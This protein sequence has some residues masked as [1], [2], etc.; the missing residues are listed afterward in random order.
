MKD[1]GLWRSLV[2]LWFSFFGASF[3]SDAQ[4]ENQRLE[5]SPAQ[6]WN[7]LTQLGV[8]GGVDNETI[9]RRIAAMEARYVSLYAKVLTEHN[10]ERAEEA[11]GCVLSVGSAEAIGH[12][13]F[14]EVF[15]GSL[16]G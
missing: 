5:L 1:R 15:S 11:N 2:H 10:T 3:R 12:Q 16:G 14:S 8:G 4:A 6:T 13:C 9:E 7:F